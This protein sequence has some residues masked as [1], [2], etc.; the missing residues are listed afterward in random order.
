[1]PLQAVLA[2]AEC[3]PL[4]EDVNVSGSA[5][6]GDEEITALVRGCPA[7]RKLNIWHT[8]TT[9]RGLCAIREY[10]APLRV[11]IMNACI[12]VGDVEGGTFFPRSVAVYL[13]EA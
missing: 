13:C 2:L 1:V 5:D 4:L 8:S 11:I 9:E 3:C 6:V 7:L 10:C 12:D